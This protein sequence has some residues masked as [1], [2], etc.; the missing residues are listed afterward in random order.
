MGDSFRANQRDHRSKPTVQP[1]SGIG[2]ARFCARHG[3]FGGRSRPARMTIMTLNFR[4]FGVIRIE[5]Y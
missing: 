3:E 1:D 5:R 4:I 2:L